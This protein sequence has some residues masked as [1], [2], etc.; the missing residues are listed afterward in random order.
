[1]FRATRMC[2]DGGGSPDVGGEPSDFAVKVYEPGAEDRELWVQKYC[3]HANVL[4]V[5]DACW[6]PFWAAIAMPL[7]HGTIFNHVVYM[8]QHGE[9]AYPYFSEFIGDIAA[10]LAH[11][12]SLDVLHLDIHSNNVLVQLNGG[13]SCPAF[14][15]SDFSLSIHLDYLPAA[16]LPFLVH[17]D[18]YRAPEVYYGAGCK[19]AI[20]NG[21]PVYSAPPTAVYSAGV[22][23]WA[24]GCLICDIC[25]GKSPCF[26]LGKE[27]DESCKNWYGRVVV[28]LIAYTGACDCI[29]FRDCFQVCEVATRVSIDVCC[30]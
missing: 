22:D 23:A 28:K 27:N 1:M 11:V 29:L 10:A 30:V 21:S 24:F 2:R 13:D 17:P 3:Y 25:G 8:K 26:G 19:I 5:V 4:G 9:G 7:C 16:G 18:I 14:L 12:H 20:H 15:L 6:T